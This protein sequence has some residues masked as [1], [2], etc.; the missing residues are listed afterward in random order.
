MPSA[1]LSAKN[2]V[3]LKPRP[4]RQRDVYYDK[5]KGAPAGFA[6]R[7]SIDGVSAYYLVYR[8]G[9]KDRRKKWLHL[10]DI[11][12]LDLADARQKAH[13]N[14]K[15]VKRKLDPKAEEQR[16]EEEREKR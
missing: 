6:L 11:D 13:E 5:S 10:G 14:R 2:V 15:L 9:K 1:V 7:V 12:T 8:F 4:G 16:Q 3:T